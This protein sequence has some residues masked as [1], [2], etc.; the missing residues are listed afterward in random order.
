MRVLKW[1]DEAPGRRRH[2]RMLD[3]PPDR[4]MVVDDVRKGDAPVAVLGEAETRR[5]RYG[6]DEEARR[7]WGYVRV[8][9]ARSRTSA[10]RSESGEAGWLRSNEVVAAMTPMRDSRTELAGGWGRQRRYNE[11]KARSEIPEPLK[12]AA[13]YWPLIRPSRYRSAELN[14]SRMLPP[15]HTPDRRLCALGPEGDLPTRSGAP[16]PGCA[17]RDPHQHRLL[18]PPLPACSI[19]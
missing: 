1:I 7:C 2:A 9:D 18:V 3:L 8:G 12:K 10:R 4:P 19:S 13:A 15:S 5:Y 14:W 17:T 11:K 6:A 16:G